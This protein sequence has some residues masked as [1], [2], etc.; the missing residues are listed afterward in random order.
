MFLGRRG[1]GSIRHH[2]DRC[3]SCRRVDNMAPKLLRG[4]TL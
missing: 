1:S 3:Q 2:V 4:E